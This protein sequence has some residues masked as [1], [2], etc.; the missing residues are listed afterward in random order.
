M[1][2]KKPRSKQEKEEEKFQKRRGNPARQTFDAKQNPIRSE[3]GSK[4]GKGKAE[5]KS[6]KSPLWRP[7][8]TRKG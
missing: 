7:N 6:R 8:Q 1:Q 2:T 4:L 5:K 3:Y